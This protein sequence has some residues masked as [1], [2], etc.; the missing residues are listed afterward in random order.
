MLAFPKPTLPPPADD[1]AAACAE[2]AREGY[3]VLRGLVDPAVIAALDSDFATPFAETPFSQGAFFGSH[4]KRFGRALI[5][6]PHAA[7]LIQHETILG[8]AEQL[9]GP[10]G[11]GIQLNLTQGIAVYP[12]A[13]AQL[14]HRDEDMWPGPKGEIE[15]MINVI[16]PFTRFVT[17]TGATRIWRG[18][19]LGD[20]EAWVPNDLCIS[21]EMEPGDAVVWLGSTLHGQGENSSDEIRRGMAVGYSQA[22]LKQYEN[23]YLAYPP[24]IARTFSTA[25]AELVGYRQLPPN[26]NNFEARSPMTLLENGD[27]HATGAVD[28]LIEFQEVASRY[29]AEHGHTRT[30]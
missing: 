18:S 19:H 6:S 11:N 8:I 9:L 2:I 7:T 4:T 1:V 23:Q 21:A 28:A 24:E 22:W 30:R 14:P 26:L 16:W 3:V 25:L 15:Y 17:E 13:P 29:Y 10:H 12:G 20:R 27:A 5:R